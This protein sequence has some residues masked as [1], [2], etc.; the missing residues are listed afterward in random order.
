MLGMAPLLAEIRVTALETNRQRGTLVAGGLSVPCALGRSGIVKDKHEGDGG[1]PEGAFRLVEVF[2]RPDRGATPATALPVEPIKPD[3]GWCDDPPDPNYNRFVRLPYGASHER[4]WLESHLYDVLVVLDYNF[5]KPAPG[6]GSAIFLHVTAPG[7][8]PTAGCVAI[9][10]EAMD[11]ILP[12][13][14]PQ[15]VIVIGQ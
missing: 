14:S 10:K 15:T 5:A 4:L 12:Q 9:S 1:T 7:F 11:Q 13:L 8:T 3:S 6:L 2:F